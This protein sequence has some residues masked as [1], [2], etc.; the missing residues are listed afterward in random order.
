MQAH[1]RLVKVQREDHGQDPRVERQEMDRGAAD[2][3][4]GHVRAAAT[5]RNR[6]AT[7]LFRL[8]ERGYGRIAEQGRRHTKA[9][10]DL[11]QTASQELPASGHDR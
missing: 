11:V 10:N 8:G 4:D 6:D 1:C 3:G 2:V 9:R 5:R 7:D